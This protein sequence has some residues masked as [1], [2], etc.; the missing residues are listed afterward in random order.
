[1]GSWSLGSNK[2]RKFIFTHNP[3]PPHNLIRIYP[4]PDLFDVMTGEQVYSRVIKRNKAVGIIPCE[5]EAERTECLKSYRLR[6]MDHPE[7]PPLSL[8]PIGE[9]YVVDEA[10]LPGG[11]VSTDNDA[12]YF[13]DCWEW[14]TSTGRVGVNMRKARALHLGQ[15]RKVRDDQLL[16]EDINMLRAIEAGDLTEQSA[17]AVRKQTLR[18]LPESFDLSM[19]SKPEEL[20]R[21]WPAELP[22]RD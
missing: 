14:R 6:H 17:V 5:S 15:I 4:N 21:H 8:P 13:F 18:D 11:V 7:A 10:D 12:K 1:M 3:Q 9:H 20:S 22:E 2:L 16:A 19:V